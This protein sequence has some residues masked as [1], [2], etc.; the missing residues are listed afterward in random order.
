MAK[1]KT[2]HQENQYLWWKDKKIFGTMLLFIVVS[3]QIFAFL[4]IPV[5]TSIHG[6]TVGMLLGFYNPL[7]YIFMAYIALLLITK[8][9]LQLPKWF[10]LK[11][12]T[13]WMI[14]ISIVFISVSAGYYQAK[15]GWLVIGGHSWSSISEWFNDFTAANNA[16]LPQNTNGGFIGVFL[17]SFFSMILSGIGAF[18]VAIFSVLVPVSLLFTGSAWGLYRKIIRKKMLSKR[19]KHVNAQQTKASNDKMIIQKEEEVMISLKDEGVMESEEQII[20]I[21]QD[22][23]DENDQSSEE[24][25]QKEEDD[26]P[27]DDPFN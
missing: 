25:D 17:Y 20:Y 21:K 22:D 8:H 6:Y 19:H 14:A 7:F 5:M 12:S 15:S 4:E 27:F 26:L 10:K 11:G 9:K 3:F 18:I 13:Y 2:H 1:T 23:E 24:E 16:W